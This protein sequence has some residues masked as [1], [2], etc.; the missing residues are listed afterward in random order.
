MENQPVRAAA[1]PE[2]LAALRARVE[3]LSRQLGPDPAGLPGPAAQPCVERPHRLDAPG[4]PLGRPDTAPG[5]SHAAGV[6]RPFGGCAV[7]PPADGAE[8]AAGGLTLTARELRAAEGP[9]ADPM[10]AVSRAHGLRRVA[11]GAGRLSA[12]SGTS[13]ADRVDDLP[14]REGRPGRTVTGGRSAAA[15]RTAEGEAA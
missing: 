10:A 8:A 13:L 5:L 4:A 1:R 15:S 9:E 12:R 7:F 11:T 6:Q 3:R 2:D 14:V